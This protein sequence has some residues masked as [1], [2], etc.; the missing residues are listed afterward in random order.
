MSHWEPESEISHFNRAAPGTVHRISEDFFQVLSAAVGLAETT[1]GAFNPCLFDRVN[2]LGFGPDIRAANSPPHERDGL[3][4]RPN[5]RALKL[6][7]TARTIV[8][9]G[10]CRLDLS[11]IAKGFAVDRMGTALQTLGIHSFLAEIGGEFVA[12]NVKPD[13]TPWWVSIETADGTKEQILAALCGNA[14]ATSGDSGKGRFAGGKRVSHIVSVS[15]RGTAEPDLA[16]VTVLGTSCMIADGWATTLFAMGG[17]AG[18]VAADRHHI[19]ALFQ[20]RDA[21][22][23]ASARMQSMLEEADKPAIAAAPRG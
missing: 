1:G 22:P 17:Q 19:A 13:L 14:L 23:A 6:N 5:W 9:P 7:D 21:P 12:G 15:A 11:A 16:S 4:D 18:V 8:Q 3:F 2:Q 10:D 20:F